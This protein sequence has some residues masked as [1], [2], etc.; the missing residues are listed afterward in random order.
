M[1]SINETTRQE[2]AAFVAALAAYPAT[3]KAKP[4]AARVKGRAQRLV[5]RLLKEYEPATAHGVLTYYRNAV[6]ESGLPGVENPASPFLRYLRLP[7]AVAK[8]R[9][10]ETKA[11]VSARRAEQIDVH[12]RRFVVEAVAAL[13][14]SDWRDKAAGVMALTGRRAAEVLLYGEFAQGEA[15]DTLTFSGQAKT[16]GADGTTQGAYQIPHLAPGGFTGAAQ[17]LRAVREIKEERPD[18]AGMP[19]DQFHDLFASKLT[20]A[21][22]RVFSG[23]ISGATPK[24]KDLRACYAAICYKRFCTKQKKN[25]GRGCSVIEFYAKILGHKLIIGAAG[26]GDMTAAAYD[27]VR[28]V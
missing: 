21:T 5:A 20:Q 25:K 3:M 2:I 11:G 24:T 7:E 27:Y 9:N 8:A 1:A 19:Y 10:G 16:R 12:A 13:S 15:E 4:L 14:A 28:V 18:L 22:R 26:G 17:I 6:R 23:V